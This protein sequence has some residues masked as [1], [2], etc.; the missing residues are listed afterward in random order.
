MRPFV[1]ALG[2]PP[3]PGERLIVDIGDINVEKRWPGFAY[4][5]YSRANTMGKGDVMKSAIYTM[6]KGF[7][8]TRF[9]QMT[10]VKNGSRKKISG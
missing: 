9:D 4:V 2:Q 8:A 6:G 7:T 10:Y 3:N 1:R 5:A